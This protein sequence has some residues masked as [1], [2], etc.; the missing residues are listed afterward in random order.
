M[1]AR[2]GKGAVQT[3]KEPAR[4]V[5]NAG[6]LAMHR[7]WRAHDIP[8]KRLSD[9]LMAKADPEHRRRFAGGANE[10]D[11]NARLV[12]R[13]RPRGENDGVRL[14]G[15]RI[16]DRDF[17]V[18]AHRHV[19]AQLAKVVDEVERE[20][21]IVVDQRDALHPGFHTSKEPSFPMLRRARQVEPAMLWRRRIRRV[22][23]VWQ[24]P[25]GPSTSA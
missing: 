24:G 20:A 12:R 3:T 4:I 8:A 7:R 13:A 23:D 18:A 17:V 22:T 15:E 16:G 19:R 10:I 21:V 6:N 25:P 2:G 1:I 9:R 5:R 11:T 14:V